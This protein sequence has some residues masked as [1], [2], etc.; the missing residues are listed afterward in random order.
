MLMINVL[1]SVDNYYAGMRFAFS[2]EVRTRQCTGL[3]AYVASPLHPDHVLLE[4]VN[5]TV[6]GPTG[7]SWM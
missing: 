4:I 5:K 2:L 1:Y 7:T 6:S 3:L